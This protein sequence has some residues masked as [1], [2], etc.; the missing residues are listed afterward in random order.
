MYN[1]TLDRVSIT[2]HF[3]NFPNSQRQQLYVGRIESSNCIYA[4]WKNL[5][6]LSL[7][8][9]HRG[10]HRCR[11]WSWYVKRFPTSKSLYLEGQGR[12]QE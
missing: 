8:P 6:W 9:G 12:F 2:S 10:R 1:T 7:L 5:S 11:S 3:G 4:A